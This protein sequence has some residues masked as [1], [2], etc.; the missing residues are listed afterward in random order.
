MKRIVVISFLSILYIAISAQTTLEWSSGNAKKWIK[1]NVWSNGWTVSPHKSV[2][3]TEFATQYHKNKE[4]WNAV[5][6]FLAN[7]DLEKLPLGNHVICEGKS[8][9][10]VSEYTP[11]EAKKGNIES[12]RRFIDL[13]YTLRGN[14]SMGLALNAEVRKEYNPERDIAFY[15][16]SKI[17]YYSTDADH[18][19]L[20]FP[21]D[22]H[23]PSIRR[24]GEPI[25]SR[26][27]VVKIEYISSSPAAQ[28]I[29]IQ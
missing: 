9:A 8:W 2:N 1:S 17:K 27:I 12:H 29:G 16:S 21:S 10:T 3:A 24:K 20:F 5:F 15:T 22:I 19:F 7:N 14:E 6:R 23:Q 28:T 4:V 18:F 25:R 11:N 26:K 13:Q